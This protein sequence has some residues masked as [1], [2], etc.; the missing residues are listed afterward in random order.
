MVN[1]AVGFIAGLLVGLLLSFLVL[2]LM[3]RP[4]RFD[5]QY[6]SVVIRFDPSIRRPR[7]RQ[8]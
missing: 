8:P 7:R 6:L 5:R 4:V 1:L 2:R 3:C